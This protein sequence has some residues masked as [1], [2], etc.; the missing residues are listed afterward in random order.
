MKK[1]KTFLSGINNMLIFIFKIDLTKWK[2][3]FDNDF[4]RFS[5]FTTSSNYVLAPYIEFLIFKDFGM[6]TDYKFR[7]MITFRLH[8]LI[9]YIVF[10]N[11]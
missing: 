8:R 2:V 5:A 3:L 4:V 10:N 1:I 6:T 9:A 11:K 7:F